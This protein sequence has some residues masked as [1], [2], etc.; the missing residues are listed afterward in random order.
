MFLCWSW[1]YQIKRQTLS[2]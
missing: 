1:I 2:I